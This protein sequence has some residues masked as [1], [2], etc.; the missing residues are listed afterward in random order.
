M[1]LLSKPSSAART[2]L[3][4]IT[5]GALLDIWT[6]IWCWYMNSHPP[7]SDAVWYFCYGLLFTGSTLLVIGFA[8]GRIGRAA[9]HA[10]LPP[11]EATP[12]EAAIEQN[13]AARAP[14]IAPVNPAATAFPPSTQPVAPVATVPGSA[15]VAPL[16]HPGTPQP[17][18]R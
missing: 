8:I 13:M 12:T 18:K 4:Y 7:E 3:I 15:P 9:R 6:G 1:P 17:A 5:L 11:P 10:D 2:A 16:A 14:V